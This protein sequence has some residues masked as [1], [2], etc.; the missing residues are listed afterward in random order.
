VRFP[1][2]FDP[3]APLSH[4]IAICAHSRPISEL[5]GF[6]TYAKSLVEGAKSR[7]CQGF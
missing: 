6:C 5:R 4:I 2:S 1:D 7:F 3:S